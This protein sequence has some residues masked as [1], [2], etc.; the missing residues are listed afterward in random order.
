MSAVRAR[1]KKVQP[2]LSERQG[3]QIRMIT[4]SQNCWAWK[5]S[6]GL[7]A[8]HSPSHP[9]NRDTQD[10]IQA[11]FGDLQGRDSITSLSNPFPCS[12]TLRIRKRLRESVQKE[13]FINLL[14]WDLYSCWRGN[15]KNKQTRQAGL[16]NW[17]FQLTVKCM[18]CIYMSWFLLRRFWAFSGLPSLPHFFF[19]P[20]LF[21]FLFSLDRNLWTLTD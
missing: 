13:H 5:E 21:L 8:P 2:G 10:H 3:N 11:A 6:L 16:Y 19:F 7:S 20:F 14:A 1:H 9:P 15:K 12:V 17:H 4:E 18:I